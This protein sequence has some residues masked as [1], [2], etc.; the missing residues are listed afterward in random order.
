MDLFVAGRDQSAADQPNYLAEGHPPI[1]T[2]WFANDVKV[3]D[4]SM[5][6]P[7]CT[8]T[9]K[10][11]YPESICLAIIVFSPSRE[12]ATRNWLQSLQGTK[13]A[14]VFA[15]VDHLTPTTLTSFQYKVT[16]TLDHIKRKG[17]DGTT[18]NLLQSGSADAPCTNTTPEHFSQQC[19]KLN[20]ISSL[21]VHEHLAQ[22]KNEQDVKESYV[23]QKNMKRGN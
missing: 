3:M 19:I 13:Q 7:I 23:A 8:Q 18:S 20:Y 15:C 4:Q 16:K 17:F 21:R 6:M 11:Y 2:I 9:A 12:T 22:Y 14:N 5:H 1:V 10:G